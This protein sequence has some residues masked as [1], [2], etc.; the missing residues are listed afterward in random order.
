MILAKDMIDYTVWANR[1]VWSV[2]EKLTDE[3]FYQ[4]L[5]EGACSLRDRYTHLAQDT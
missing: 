5:G 1:T 3:E 2:I 4:S